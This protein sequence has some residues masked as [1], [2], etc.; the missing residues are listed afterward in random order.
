MSPDRFDTIVRQF[1]SQK[2]LAAA[3]GVGQPTIS[4]I[5]KRRSIRSDQIDAI[6]AAARERGLPI[7]HADFFETEAA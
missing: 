7:S 5:K 4:K 3:I 6:V 2:A 1:G